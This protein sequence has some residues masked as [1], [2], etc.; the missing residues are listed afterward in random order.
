M[1]CLCLQPLL[2]LLKLELKEIEGIFSSRVG[3]LVQLQLWEH[4]LQHRGPDA[5]KHLHGLLSSQE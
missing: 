2:F 1:Q 5:W 4:E 3:D